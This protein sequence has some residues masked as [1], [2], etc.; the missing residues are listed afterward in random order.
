M[1]I[2]FTLV[3]HVFKHICTFLYT[4]NYGIVIC[5]LTHDLQKKCYLQVCF[6]KVR[7]T[8]SGAG[9]EITPASSEN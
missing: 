5:L 4:L 6:I 2:L 8:I 7:N 3:C 1:S 9:V